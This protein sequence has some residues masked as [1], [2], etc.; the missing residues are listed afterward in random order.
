MKKIL[1]LLLAVAMLFSLAACGGN[2][3]NE[4]LGM[5][6]AP[7]AAV[8]IKADYQVPEDFKVGFICLHDEKSTYDLNFLKGVDA[9]KAAIGLTDAQV[10][11][12][13]NVP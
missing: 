7:L 8:E 2:N 1:A 4:T 9:I 13:K 11:I 10:L 3:N 6:G 12:K 5:S